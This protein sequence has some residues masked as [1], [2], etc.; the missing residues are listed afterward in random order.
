MRYPAWTSALAM[1]VGLLATSGVAQVVDFG[2][3]PPLGGQWDR[4]APPNNWVV[5]S[6]QPPLTPECHGGN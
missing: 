3:Y 4:T 2:K 1:A 6:G 5:Q